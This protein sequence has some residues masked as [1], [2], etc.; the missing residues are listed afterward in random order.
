MTYFQLF[1]ETRS[2]D[3]LKMNETEAIT[4]KY[5][6]CLFF[7]STFVH[8]FDKFCESKT[9]PIPTTPTC[10]PTNWNMIYIPVPNNFPEASWLL[11]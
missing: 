8:L 5:R 7:P 9:A 11:S 2:S 3:F 10:N 6:M 4:K 1:G